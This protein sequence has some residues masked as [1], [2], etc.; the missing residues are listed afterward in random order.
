[1]VPSEASTGQSRRL[2]SVTK[3]GNPR[4]RALLV[5]MAWRMVR[6]QPSYHALQRWRTV[7]QDRR[8]KA[9][10]KRAIVAVARVLAIDLWRLITGQT[11]M[12]KLGLQV[13]AH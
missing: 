12:S 2:G 1:L 8:N 10:R 11:T 9:G 13:S 6:Y 7:L 4:I 3:V 5:E